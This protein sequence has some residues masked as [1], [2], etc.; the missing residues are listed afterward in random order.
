MSEDVKYDFT[1]EFL[2]TTPALRLYA[3]SLV[4]K[5]DTADDLVQD[6]LLRAWAAQ[7]QFEPGTSIRAWMFTI[8][9]HRYLDICRRT[10]GASL[11]LEAYV[12][13]LA[14]SCPAHQDSHIELQEVARAFWRLSA[15]HREIILL[16]GVIGLSYEAAAN[17]VGCR[18]GTIRS[19]L[20]RARDELQK[21]L[22][23]GKGPCLSQK[24]EKGD[25]HLLAML[26]QCDLLLPRI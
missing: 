15:D 7:H 26:Q 2:A 8:M 12:D 16:V 3:R 19:R 17:I 13:H 21:H 9:R 1:R 4:R 5:V 25:R 24:P 23:R 18:L 14:L 22:E 6:T 20:S 11:E 10:K